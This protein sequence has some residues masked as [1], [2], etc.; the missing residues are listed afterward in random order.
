MQRKE[1]KLSAKSCAS[2][3]DVKKKTTHKHS[4]LSGVVRLRGRNTTVNVYGCKQI[5]HGQIWM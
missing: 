2:K 3:H 5:T 4:L 1:E